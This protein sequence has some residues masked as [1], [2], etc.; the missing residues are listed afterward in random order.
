MKWNTGYPWGNTH[1]HAAYMSPTQARVSGGTLSLVAEHKRDPAAPHGVYAD[2]AYHV[3]DYTSGAVNTQG[4]L[5]F[6]GGYVEA[7]MKM[8][9]TIGS[10]PAFWMLQDG[11]PPEI[12]IMEFPVM[13]HDQANNDLYRYYANYHWGTVADH[14]SSG[15]WN[16]QG[17]DLSAGFHNYGLKWETNR[18]TYYLDGREVHSVSG[19]GVGEAAGEY[20]IL[21]NAVGGWAGTPQSCRAGAT[22]ST[23]TGCASGSRA[24]TACKPTGTATATAGSPMTPTGRAA[25]PTCRASGR[26]SPPRPARTSKST[27]TA[28]R[29]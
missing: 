26:G 14:K 20:L 27:G 13:D 21:N 18:L 17:D 10:W 19:A 12:D 28:A 2:G 24:A 8:G 7:R 6:T 23:S 15:R 22:R 25:R 9:G 5:N 4:K 1:N 11:W 29:P 16:W 3:L